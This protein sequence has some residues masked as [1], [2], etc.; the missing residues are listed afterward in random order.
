MPE[1]NENS[2]K[3][4]EFMKKKISD[5]SK[6]KKI[7][8]ASGQNKNNN[9]AG[10]DDKEQSPD[11]LSE[12]EQLEEAKKASRNKSAQ[13]DQSGM[14]K[15]MIIENIIKYTLLTAL[16]VLFAIGIIK[17]GPAMVKFFNGL[18]SKMLFSA[19]SR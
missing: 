5:K 8:N 19:I 2:S 6:N 4:S 11:D 10:S 16:L 15:K 18:I 9:K 1:Q 17:F 13:Q 7:S 14:I 3:L 12:E